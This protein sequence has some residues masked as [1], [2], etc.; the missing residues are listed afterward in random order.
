MSWIHL[1]LSFSIPT[2]S[3]H[4]LTSDLDW[5]LLIVPISFSSKPSIHSTVNV[6]QTTLHFFITQKHLLA[7]FCLQNSRS[8]SA[9][10]FKVLRNSAP[11]YLS[12]LSL[13]ILALTDY[14]HP[15]FMCL[16][17]A[18]SPLCHV[19]SFPFYIWNIT[20]FQG[21]AKYYFL[22]EALTDF[23]CKKSCQWL[24]PLCFHS[25]LFIPLLP[26]YNSALYYT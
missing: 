16:Y 10:S 18:I 25:P 24:P 4:T 15:V 5:C 23:Y 22:Y 13:A 17:Y 14:S 21:P 6:T 11:P 8:L 20:H 3:V 1:L 7:P 9:L 26:N 19:F 2:I 12:N